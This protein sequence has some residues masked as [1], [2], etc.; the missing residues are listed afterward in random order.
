[1]RSVPDFIILGAMKSGTTTLFEYL[2][3]HPGIFMASPK[4][5]QFFSRKF[6]E[7][8]GLDWYR[9]LFSG[10]APG[11][12]TG[13]AST[14]Y[15]R[16]PH[17]GDVAARISKIAPEVRFLYIM[18]H[19]VDRTFS[20]FK[21]LM[22]ERQL[23]G[24][25]D[26]IEFE[27]AIERFPE[28]LD[29]SHYMVQINRYLAHFDRSRFLFLTTDDLVR[30]ASDVLESAQAFLGLDPIDLVGA[31]PV[32]ANPSGVAVTKRR[33]NRSV[34]RLARHPWVQPFR[35]MVPEELRH[36]LRERVTHSS[37]V[38]NGFRAT[39]KVTRRARL[40]PA[41]R[42]TL[43]E[44]FAEPTRELESFLERDLSDWYA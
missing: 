39:S 25:S 27:A 10:R 19:P 11:Q 43:L 31:E 3:M 28:L 21:H 16:W 14:C 17:Y 30:G 41:I 42:A 26:P 24:R 44:R 34:T 13:E 12:L 29:A 22:H 35:D 6:D 7:P 18:R 1:M 9:S 4:E 40:T 2:S 8:S 23:Q 38:A 15:S 32:H 36:R 33:L 20:N 5:P 37:L